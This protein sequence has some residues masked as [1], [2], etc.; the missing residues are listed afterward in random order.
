MNEEPK[1]QWGCM[2]WGMLV[3]CL[4]FS[5]WVVLPAFTRVSSR[6]DSMIGM[7][8]CKQIILSLKQYSK[9]HDS[10]FPDH[11]KVAVHSSNEVFRELFKEGIVTDERIFGC[12]QSIF[13]PDNVIGDPPGFEKALQPG[14]C[15]WML[16]KGQS[17]V[18]HPETPLVIE[19]SLNSSWPPRWE[20]TSGS[21]LWM[22]SERVAK[23]GCSWPGGRILIGRV[24]GSVSM[25]KLR[26]DGTIDWHAYGTPGPDG[27][28]WI[29]T[30]TPEQLS[31]L[32]YWDIEEK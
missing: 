24:D 30:L 23:K 22:R 28:R 32:S 8:K 26:P 18:S 31:K 16:L 25:E 15:H 3:A 2:Q 27:K 20:V 10:A 9:D 4:L 17:D 12:P 14:E 29:D 19:K 13:N 11:G 1:E 7:N 6:G 21:S 5:A